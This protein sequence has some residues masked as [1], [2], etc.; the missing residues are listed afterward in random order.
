MT[1][2]VDMQWKSQVKSKA[3]EIVRN[4]NVNKEIQG[5]SAVLYFELFNEKHFNL[6]FG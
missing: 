5:E 4:V 3:G 2:K 6:M 1:R